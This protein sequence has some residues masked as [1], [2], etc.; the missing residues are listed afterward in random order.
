MTERNDWDL[1][2]EPFT[3]EAY[4]KPMA[5]IIIQFAT[6]RVLCSGCMRRFYSAIV[7]HEDA[8]CSYQ[9]GV[10][11]Q[12]DYCASSWGFTSVPG[13]QPK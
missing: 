12:P 4:V 10:N 9:C 5:A 7:H 6:R 2:T 8:Y 13:G 1:G 11:A 3:V